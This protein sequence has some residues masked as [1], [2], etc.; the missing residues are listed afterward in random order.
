MKIILR[1]FFLITC[2][3]LLIVCYLGLLC[4]GGLIEWSLIKESFWQFLNPFILVLV[5]IQMLQMPITYIL[6]AFGLFANWGINKLDR[7]KE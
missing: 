6:I 7:N 5:I 1:T 4:I 2:Y 3:I